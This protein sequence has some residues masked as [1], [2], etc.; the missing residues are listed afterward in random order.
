MRPVK[1]LRLNYSEGIDL[2]W[3]NLFS[4]YQYELIV[5]DFR[6]SS[7]QNYTYIAF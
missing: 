4:A 5:S 6:H 7:D 2:P 3:K 1:H